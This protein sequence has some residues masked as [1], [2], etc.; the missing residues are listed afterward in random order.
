MKNYGI[1]S[2]DGEKLSNSDKILEDKNRFWGNLTKSVLDRTPNNVFGILLHPVWIEGEL[3]WIVRES[4][5]WDLEAAK[6][7]CKKL[8]RCRYK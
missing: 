2:V 1:Y 6:L 5:K 3:H 4:E 7:W 8:F